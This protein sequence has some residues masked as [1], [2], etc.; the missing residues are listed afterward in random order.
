MTYPTLA[1]HAFLNDINNAISYSFC[2]EVLVRILAEG[3]HP[4]NFFI[5]EERWWN[6]LDLFVTLVST[7]LINFSGQNAIN[8]LR[9]LRILRISK[10]FRHIEALHVIMLGLLEG[11]TSILY[12][13]LLL[14]IV[15]YIYAI[16]GVIF[17][18][19][20]DPWHFK[21][22]EY[23]ALSLFG[24]LTLSNWGEIYFINALGCENYGGKFCLK[25][26]S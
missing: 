14:F 23:S 8:S 2:F 9:L 10:V 4:L 20:N 16:A 13:V 26:T 6:N 15:L 3:T 18:G 7:P 5:G 19:G 21:T 1:K 11:M 22:V 12:I 17:F 25:N 24:T